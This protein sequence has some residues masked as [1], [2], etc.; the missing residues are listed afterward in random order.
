MSTELNK[1]AK[2]PADA[3]GFVIERTAKRM[4]QYYQKMLR[5]ANIG[6]TVD[7]WILL[8]AIHQNDGSSQFEIASSTFKDAPTVTRI[9]DL[10]SNKKL[11]ERVADP[12]DRRRYNIKITK[13]GKKQVE[14]I[15]PVVKSFRAKSWN[16]LT[17]KQLAEMTK[18][19]NKVFDNLEK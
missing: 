13:Q 16:G 5:D 4:K 9:L 8:K 17:K 3:F 1:M 11:I 12:S 19:L 10:L 7:Q 6:I 18:L 15:L 14:E 2:D